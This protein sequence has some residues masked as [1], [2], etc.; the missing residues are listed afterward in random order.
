[1]G[2]RP[3]VIPGVVEIEGFDRLPETVF[4]EFPE[5]DGSVHDQIKGFGP[6]Q[7]SAKRF[8]RH[9]CSKIDKGCFRRCGHRELFD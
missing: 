5:P 2:E 6:A 9:G 7:S 4:G 1:M 3:E 8:G